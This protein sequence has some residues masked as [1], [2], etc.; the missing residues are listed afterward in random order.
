MNGGGPR[1]PAS[2]LSRLV[3]ARRDVDEEKRNGWINHGILV[4]NLADHKLGWLEREMIK[5]LGNKLYGTCREQE[6]N[7]D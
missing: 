6:A 4:V 5:Q 1:Q 3:P 2:C 7:D